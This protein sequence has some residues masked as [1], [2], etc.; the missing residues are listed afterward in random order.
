MPNRAD[1]GDAGAQALANLLATQPRKTSP[2]AEVIA[3]GTPEQRRLTQKAEKQFYQEHPQDTL[4]LTAT[5]W[6][7]PF[8]MPIYVDQHGERHSE[9]STTIQLD[10]T[11]PNSEWVTVPKIWPDPKTG[12]G[13]YGWSDDQIRDKVRNLVNPVSGEQIQTFDTSEQAV[14]YAID[15]D[16]MLRDPKHPWNQ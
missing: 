12:K 13:R 16:L 10:P 7:S 9:S 8:G 15:R 4:E 1:Y 6:T 5:E 3:S 11:D 2:L 14:Q